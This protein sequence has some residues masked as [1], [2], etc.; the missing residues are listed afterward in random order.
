MNDLPTEDWEAGLKAESFMVLGDYTP[1]LLT[2]QNT[3]N[4]VVWWV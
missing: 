1:D 3:N 4:S 2:K